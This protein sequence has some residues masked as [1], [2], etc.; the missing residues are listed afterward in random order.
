VTLDSGE[1]IYTL[2]ALLSNTDWN[3]K[4]ISN[5]DTIFGKG[6]STERIFDFLLGHCADDAINVIYG[7]SYDF[8]MWL[9]DFT[10]E[11]LRGLYREESFT[12]RNYRLQWRTGKTFYIRR[13]DPIFGKPIGTGVTI[14]DVVSFFQ[15]T[16]VNAC[17]SYLGDRFL[18]RERI[19]EQKANRGKFTLE[20]AAEVEIYN[21]SELQNLIMLVEELRA[22]L[23]KVHLRPRRWDGPGAV[24]AALLTR[25]GVKEAKAECPSEVAR[26]A[27]FAYAGGRFEVIRWGHVEE[28]AYEYDVNSAYPAALRFVPDLSK[29]HWRHHEGE[30]E[31]AG[32]FTVYRIVSRA[33]FGNLPA[34]LFCRLPKGSIC[35]PR[36]VEGWYWSPEYEVTKEYCKRGYGSYE[37]L[38]AWEFV[39]SAD[40]KPFEF[41]EPLYLKRQA[42]KAGKDGAH[43]GIKLALNSLYGKLAQQVGYSEKRG[44]LRLPPYHQLEWAGFTTSYCRAK[45]LGACL[46]KLESVIAF[47][48]DAVF[49]SEPLDV[50]ISNKLGD[51]EVTE[52]ADLTYIQS[53]LYFGESDA[54]IS[55]TRGVDRGNLSRQYVLERMADPDP[56]KRMATVGLT[57]FVGAGIALSQN[58]ARWRRWESVTKEVRLEPSG[59]RVHEVLFACKFCMQDSRKF[60][61][62]PDGANFDVSPVDVGVWHETRCPYVQKTPIISAEYPVAWINPDAN[63]AELEELREG[64]VSDEW[65]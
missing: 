30:P 14:Y 10:E 26:A 6:L 58:Y 65:E 48:T 16:F 46:D 55:K 7:G 62:G 52:F 60:R 24:A 12:W 29:G 2:L 64:S 42:L 5:G 36:D 50:P 27:R 13:L 21:R 1:H 56:F 49:T 45:V 57:R 43:V 59:K 51:F 63:M 47:E 15:T 44:R 11:E 53:G 3:V 35:Y 61:D 31:N 4:S 38:E 8:N 23:N 39:P 34:P 9:R 19:V 22:R 40:R 33:L 28:K 25:E 32:T 54:N 20:D 37:V 17:D 18:D 41:I